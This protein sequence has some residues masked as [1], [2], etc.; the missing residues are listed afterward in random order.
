MVTDNDEVTIGNG[1]VKDLVIP[2]LSL[3]VCCVIGMIWTGGF[4]AGENFVTA[5][6]NSDASVGL[7]VGSAFALVI[8]IALYVSRQS[9]WIQRMH[10]LHPGGIQ[11]HGTGYH[12]PDLCMDLESHD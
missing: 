3:I 1:G 7:A 10:G 2:I 8:T 4:F 11:S 12:D 5:F 6:S 9:A